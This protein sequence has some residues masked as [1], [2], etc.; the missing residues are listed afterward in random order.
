M[1]RILVAF[2][3]LAMALVLAAQADAGSAIARSSHHATYMRSSARA[4]HMPARLR[5]RGRASFVSA[6]T[7]TQAIE[8]NEGGAVIGGKFYVPG[9]LETGGTTTY[10]FVQI[11]NSTTHTWTVDTAHPFALGSSGQPLSS[12]GAVCTD[13]TRV[14]FINGADGQFIYSAFQIYTPGTGWTYGTLPNDGTGTGTNYF[15]SQDSGCAVLGGKVYLF[16]GYGLFANQTAETF[17]K[18]TLVYDPATQLWSNTGKNMLAGGIWSGYG[19]VQTQ[20]ALYG[21][22]VNNVST[23]A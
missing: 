12:D 9:G 15:Y 22:G 20:V 8:E 17:N 21:G 13:G 1:R 23:F 6:G 4:V 7:M 3:T 18:V 11:Y 16:G 19:Q 10:G 5:P 2:G 14:F